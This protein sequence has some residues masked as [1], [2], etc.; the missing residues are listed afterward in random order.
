M[1]SPELQELLC[2]GLAVLG[3]VLV[4]HPACRRFALLSRLPA[5]PQLSRQ[6]PSAVI[7]AAQKLW[8]LHIITDVPHGAAGTVVRVSAALGCVPVQQPALAHRRQQRAGHSPQHRE[9]F[10]EGLAHQVRALDAEVAGEDGEAQ[11][12]AQQDEE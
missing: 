7:T 9:R 6:L 1:Y 12:D 11:D 8:L 4:Q 10:K 5:L 3:C 2:T